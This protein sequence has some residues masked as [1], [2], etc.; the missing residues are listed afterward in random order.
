MKCLTHPECPKYLQLLY[1][2]IESPEVDQWTAGQQPELLEVIAQEL[3]CDVADILDFELSLYDTQG[4]ALSGSRGKFD[5]K[6]M[7]TFVFPFL[8]IFL[9]TS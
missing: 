3:Q 1:A 7:F 4:A 2:G 9:F 5:V 8:R 6:W